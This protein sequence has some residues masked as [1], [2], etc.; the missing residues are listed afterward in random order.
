M[1]KLISVSFSS[2]LPFDF[3]FFI[4]ILLVVWLLGK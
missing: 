4:I 1:S 3:F 2:S